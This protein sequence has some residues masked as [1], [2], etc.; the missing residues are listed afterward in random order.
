MVSQ[1]ILLQGDAWSVLAENLIQLIWSIMLRKRL[2][3]RVRVAAFI[4]DAKIRT[5]TT[6]KEDCLQNLKQA[7]GDTDQEPKAMF[8]TQGALAFGGIDAR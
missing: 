6:S 4:D 7:Y 2:Q 1:R 5:L 3:N 8:L